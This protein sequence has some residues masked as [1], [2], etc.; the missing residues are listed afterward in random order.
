MFIG[1]SRD[2]N[3]TTNR[4]IGQAKTGLDGFLS[5]GAEK[6]AG[7]PHRSHKNVCGV[8]E[9]S[10]LVAFDQ[11]SQPCEGEGGGNE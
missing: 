5:F 11:M 9:E 1:E 8:G 2:L 4:P 3:G 10:G 7:H 6:F